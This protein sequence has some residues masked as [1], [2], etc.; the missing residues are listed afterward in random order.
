MPIIYKKCFLENFVAECEK[1]GQKKKI[2]T[3]V[4]QWFT[5]WLLVIL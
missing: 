2:K 4:L 1:W 3:K 5:E